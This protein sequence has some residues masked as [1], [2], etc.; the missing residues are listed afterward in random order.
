MIAVD[1]RFPTWCRIGR[2]FSLESCIQV[3][4]LLCIQP[5]HGRRQCVPTQAAINNWRAAAESLPSI[6]FNDE[7]EEIVS[8]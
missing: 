2:C 5:F 3:A 8:Q 6:F 7:N 1:C 4:L